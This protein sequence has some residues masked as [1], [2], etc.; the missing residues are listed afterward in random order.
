MTITKFGHSCLLIEEN[1]TRIVLDPGTF[2]TEQNSLKDIDVIL[3]THEHGDHLSVDSI[4]EIVKNNPEVKILT[5]ASV[6]AIL[7][8]E[9]IP[10]TVVKH[11][12]VVTEKGVTFEG[13]GETH[14]VLINGVPPIENIGFII[15]GRLFYPGDALTLA[16]KPIEILALPAFAPWSKLSETVDYT[17]AVHPKIAFPVHDAILAHP[18]MMGHWFTEI[19]SKEGIEYK[20][21]DLNK[22]YE[23]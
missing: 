1:G 10:A 12:D 6:A 7:E 9:A 13:V 23:F 16:E 3:I 8:K 2:T 21:V 4:K 15:A 11:G 17:I 5:N 22:A 19:F 14:A 18:G 20:A